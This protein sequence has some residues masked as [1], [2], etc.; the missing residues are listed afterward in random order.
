[1]N[2]LSTI[3]NNAADNYLIDGL[4]TQQPAHSSE[5]SCISVSEATANYFKE[6]DSI[7]YAWEAGEYDINVVMPF[8]TSLGLILHPEDERDDGEFHEFPK[9]PERQAVRYA[10]LKF[11]A[12]IAEEEGL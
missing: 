2:K 3:L 11:A 12:M 1:M 6:L 10:W 7:S 9:G 8:L 5:Y 4:F